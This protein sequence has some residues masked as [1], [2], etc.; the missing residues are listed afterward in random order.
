MVVD[1]DGMVADA[2]AGTDGGG[3]AVTDNTPFVWGSVSKS[4]TAAVVEQL[5]GRSAL[6]RDDQVVALVPGAAEVLR[7]RATTVGDLLD[8]TSGL[9]HDTSLTDRWDR[10]GSAIGAIPALAGVDQSARGTFRYS[11]LNY[12]LL[13]AVVEQTTGGSFARALDTELVGGFGPAESAGSA[14]PVAPQE[15]L[16]TVPAGTVPFFGG[17][18]P[19]HVGVD[20]AGLGYGYLAG[21][22]EQLGTFVSGQIRSFRAGA[23]A[24]LDGVPTGGG[25][26][27]R[28]GWYQQSVTPAGAGAAQMYWHSGAVPGYFT[29]V[30]MVPELGIGIVLLTNRYGELDADHIAALAQGFVDQQLLGASND[31]ATGVGRWVVLGAGILLVVVLLGW[32]VSG[33]RRTVRRG[34]TARWRPLTEASSGAA[35][36]LGVL[37][38]TPLLLGIGWQQAWRWAPDLVVLLGILGAAAVVVVGAALVRLRAI[39]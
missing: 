14:L 17:S 22:V 28:D 4:V 9:P 16:S 12:L 8:H 37:V 15:F 39:R 21:S 23:S 10:R 5:I 11:S 3:R 26:R 6:A 35:I 25:M 38:G 27:Y 29:H 34:R 13:Q 30:A 7:D 24:A 36:V 31:T 20:E 33:V 19:Q 1:A 18:L 32:A 2:A